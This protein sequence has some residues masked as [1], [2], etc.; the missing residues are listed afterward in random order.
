MD[1]TFY[2]TTPIKNDYKFDK[3]LGEYDKPYLQ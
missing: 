1:S 2:K 3:V